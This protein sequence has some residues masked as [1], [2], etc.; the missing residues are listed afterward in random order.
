[1]TAKRRSA[2]D[3]LTWLDEDAPMWVGGAAFVLGIF[4]AIATLVAFFTVLGL[5]FRIHAWLGWAVLAAAVWFGPLGLA[6]YVWRRYQQD[7]SA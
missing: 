4:G 2:A 1:M 3:F 6:R 7:T 5:A